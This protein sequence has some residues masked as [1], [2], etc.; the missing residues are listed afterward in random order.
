[1]SRAHNGMRTRDPHL[2]KVSAEY[3]P[4]YIYV[5]PQVRSRLVVRGCPRIAGLF[6]G[7][8]DQMLTTSQPDGGSGAA[9]TWS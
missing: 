3:G 1:M 9:G 5:F 2:G 4:Y 6:L 7:T 8:V